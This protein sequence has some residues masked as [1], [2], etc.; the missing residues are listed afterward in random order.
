M[1]FHRIEPVIAQLAPRLA[2]QAG[3]DKLALPVMERVLDHGALLVGSA[4]AG[5]VGAEPVDR[6]LRARERGLEGVDRFL[7]G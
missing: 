2:F 6:A 4:L 1:R 5:L 7:R 3:G